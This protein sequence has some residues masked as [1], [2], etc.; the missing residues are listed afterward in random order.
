[1]NHLLN[2]IQ[3]DIKWRLSEI[4]NIKTIPLRYNL[5]N[6]HKKTLILYSV[7]SFYAIWEGFLKQTFQLLTN[8]LNNA[9]LDPSKV[10]IN[11]L[12]HAIEN[13]CNLG[14]SR[15]HFDS[16]VNLVN[17]AINLYDSKL[18]IKQGIPTESNANY[19]VTNKILERFN[20]KNIDSKYEKPLNR[21]LFFRNKIAHGENSIK[22][23]SSDIDEFSLLVENL[24]Y[25]ILILI[26]EFIENGNYK[27]ENDL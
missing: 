17:S 15:K 27:K 22:V 12:T 7:P 5:L 24:M 13:E 1:M 9:I 4:T 19:K 23:Y 8:Y 21:L 20:I 25:N 11:I 16:K 26:E 3:E 18:I 6:V 14:N 2:E 10:H